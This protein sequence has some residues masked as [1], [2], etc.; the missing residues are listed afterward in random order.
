MATAA[1]T[2]SVAVIAT[3]VLDGWLD[4]L[5]GEVRNGRSD[6]GAGSPQRLR[7]RSSISVTRSSSRELAPVVKDLSG[8]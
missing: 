5:H 3:L 6:R 4:P 1:V 7:V 8:T 2:L